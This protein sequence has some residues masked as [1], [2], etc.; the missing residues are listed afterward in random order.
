MRG[1]VNSVV[2]HGDGTSTITLTQGKS[3]IIDTAS[4]SMVATYR[5]CAER[6]RNTYYAKTC[7][8]TRANHASIRM[9]SLLL[10]LTR[11]LFPDHKD[12]DG[13]NNRLSNLRQSTRGQNTFN[14]RVRA[15]KTSQFFGV[16]TY[17]P[18]GKWQAQIRVENK[19]YHLGHFE[20]ELE[21]KQARDQAELMYRSDFR[22]EN[23]GGV[24]SIPIGA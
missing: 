24:Q 20:T 23:L 11:P 12:G 13:L 15:G 1:K 4:Y 7:V 17:G 8:G 2:H 5:W 9:H 21:A 22:R 3:T 16:S 14:A 10:P 18:R 6:G 19:N